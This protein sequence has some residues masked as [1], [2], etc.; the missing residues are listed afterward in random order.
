MA[1]VTKFLFDTE[2]GEVPTRRIVAREAAA[3]SAAAAA[4]VEEPPP[5]PPPPMFSED[6]L[7]LA[8]QQ[9]F[10]AGKRAG[11]REAEAASERMVAAALQALAAH[12]P[13]LERNQ[14]ELAGRRERNAV[15][16]ALAVAKRMLP[17]LAER[18]GVGELEALFAEHLSHLVE[19]PRLTVR[20]HEGVLDVARERL[21]AVAEAAGFEGRLMVV[22]DPAVPLGDGRIEWGEGGMERSQARFWQDID[23]AVARGLGADIEPEDAMPAEL[24]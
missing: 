12:L 1:A 21:N 18:E 2:F 15:R 17:A 3:A 22:G 7:E 13:V 10:E 9:A 4:A 16:A 20:V 6:E 8:R 14:V 19:E 5:P 24:E 11:I 23:A